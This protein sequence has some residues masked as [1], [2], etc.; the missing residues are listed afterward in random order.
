MLEYIEQCIFFKSKA[1][2]G[3][4]L[5]DNLGL[6]KLSY[7]FKIVRYNVVSKS[8]Y[9]HL[10]LLIYSYLTHEFLHDIFVL[11]L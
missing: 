10:N 7:Q 3:L 8:P 1:F 4:Q 11:L 9:V 6:L 5:F 2:L